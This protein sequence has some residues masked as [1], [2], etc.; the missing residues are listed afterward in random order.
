MKYL[1][2][3]KSQEFV[4]TIGGLALAGV[5]W[6]DAI[7]ELRVT[8]DGRSSP[9]PLHAQVAARLQ[10]LIETGGLPVGS[11]IQSEVTLA[12]RLG[13]SR[14]TMRRAM[15]HLVDRGL[16]V[17][18]PGVGTEVV[19]PSVRR[20]VELASLYDDLVKA[21]RKPSTDVLSFAVIPASD[22]V[23]LAL[24]IPPRT[25]VTSIDRLRYADGQPLALMHNLVPV[26]IARLARAELQRHGLYE[27]LR[28][29]AVVPKAAD[30]VIGARSATAEEAEAL[31]IKRGAPVLTM[32]RTAWNADGRGVE[33]G[34]HVYR[35]DRYAF[36]H[37][38]R[39]EDGLPAG[40]PWHLTEFPHSRL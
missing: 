18:K 3:L 23:A 24:H 29:A 2:D 17:R 5:T 1:S 26:H 13:I 39:A 36:Q 34:S 7:A 33:Y 9:L 27:L 40:A 11:R 8:L 30:E 4:R 25:E 37:P 16:V 32:T 12:E 31:G 19:M 28:A 20:P 35:A 6:D 10:E 15:Q 14:P 38:V 22:A 21:G